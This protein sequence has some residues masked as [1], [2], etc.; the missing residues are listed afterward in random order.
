MSARLALAALLASAC[1]D[2]KVQDCS[3][4]CGANDSCPSGLT[5]GG[6][7]LCRKNPNEDCVAG[8]GDAR[9]GVPD[10]RKGQPDARTLPD[11]APCNGQAIG[12]PDNSCPGEPTF[13]ILEGSHQTFDDRRI[14]PAGDVDVYTANLALLPHPDCHTSLSYALQ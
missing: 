7:G 6:D 3:I 5:C 10:A 9:V 4:L 14:F 11:A 1:Y 12:E 13:P 2:P 8:M